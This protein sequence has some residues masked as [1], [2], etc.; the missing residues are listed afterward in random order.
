MNDVLPKPFT[1]EGLIAMLEK[2]LSHLKK[3]PIGID[4][5][6]APPLPK[7]NRSLK[8]EESPATSPATVSNW[9]SPNNLSGVSPASNQADDSTSVYSAA[10]YPMQPG[11]QPAP[12]YNAAPP[13]GAPPRQPQPPPR[14]GIGDISGGGAEM[15]DVKRQQMYPPPPQP[16][17]GQPM[18]QPPMR[19]PR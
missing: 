16:A 13:M 14:R 4:P 1:K 18:Q 8:S 17:M 9:N 15:G 2:H 19:P 10:S 5:M 12:M 7:A 11:L 6:A 3:H